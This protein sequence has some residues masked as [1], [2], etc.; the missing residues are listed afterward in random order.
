MGAS[1]LHE[2]SIFPLRGKSIPINIRN[3]NLP[4]DPGTLIVESGAKPSKY[5]ITGIA[6]KKNFCSINIEKD[7]MNNAVGF[8]RRV[9][10][11]F[12]DAHIPVEH[13]PTGIDTMTVFVNQ[14]DFIAKEQSVVSAIHSLV[15]PDLMEIESDLA[16]IAV[17]GRG[18]RSTQGRMAATLFSALAAA[19]IH[20][21]MLDQG[22]SEINIIIGVENNDFEPAIQAIYDAFVTDNA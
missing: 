9:L 4:D 20:T 1:V 19:K 7:R 5:T 10:S 11:A 15:E 16:L 21:H 22:S 2:D 17:V 12:E 3:T 18:I 14:D 6:G 13:V 8:V